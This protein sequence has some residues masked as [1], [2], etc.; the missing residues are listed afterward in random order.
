MKKKEKEKKSSFV[1]FISYF[2]L[3]IFLIVVYSHFI[4]TKGLFIREYSVINNRIPESFDGFKI[5]HF[6]DLHYGTTIKETELK[7]LV[8][9][10]NELKPDIV[11]F[12]GDLIDIDYNINDKEIDI[13]INELNN[14]DS[15][16][17]N[18][19]IRGNHDINK[20]YSKVADK[21]NFIDLNNKNTLLYYNSQTPIRLVGLDD[22]LEHTLNITDAFNY[23]LEEDLYTI[24]IAHEPDVIDKLNDYKIDLMFSGHSHNGQ[25]RLPFI[26]AVY[27]PVGSKKYYD[28][29]YTINNTNLYIS[30]GIGT[31]T[32]EFRLFN[33]PSFNFY[34]LYIN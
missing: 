24:V 32:A 34:R 8:K 25:V 5:V 33:H 17:D 7:K 10:I 9:E 14:I 12:T 13:L 29:E 2:L 15:N 6:S 16:I 1:K 18:Y 20:G 22:Y 4:G 28:E 21:I 31:S 19:I 3:I 27:T 23:N 26:G 30:G 11:I